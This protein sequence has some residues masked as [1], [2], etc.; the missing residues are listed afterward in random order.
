M[1]R[2]ALIV[3]G[4]CTVW[5]GGCVAET[6]TPETTGADELSAEATGV[7]TNA[8]TAIGGDRGMRADLSKVGTGQQ[9]LLVDTRPPPQP[10]RQAEPPPPAPGEGK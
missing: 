8:D 10:Y 6:Q 3:L 9:S 4:V 2:I 5:L 1:R 7:S